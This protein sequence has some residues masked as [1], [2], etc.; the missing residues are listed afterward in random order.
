[1]LPSYA[2]AQPCNSV[3]LVRG[4]SFETGSLYP[5][6]TKS[7]G[8]AIAAVTPLN[9]FSGRCSSILKCGECLYR[10][11]V[12]PRTST[13][14]VIV[15]GPAMRVRDRSHFWMPPPSV[16]SVMVPS[17]S[18][19][20]V[21]PPG[22]GFEDPGI[23]RSAPQPG[24]QPAVSAGLLRPEQDRTGRHTTGRSFLA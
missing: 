20:Q 23:Y 4:S 24:S 1:M 10:M 15:I 5:Y 3:N 19:R 22:T 7:I 6:W 14:Q 21:R 18:C 12:P 11:S 8:T 13:L 16:P 2:V 17:L 9:A